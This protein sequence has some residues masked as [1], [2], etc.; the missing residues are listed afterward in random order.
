MAFKNRNH[1]DMSLFKNRLWALMDKNGYENPKELAAAL[2]EA[3]IKRAVQRDTSNKDP[4]DLT[5]SSDGSIEKTIQRHLN[6]NTPDRIKGEWMLVYSKFFGCSLDYLFG[7]E[8]CQEHGTQ[9]IHEY[10]GLTEKTI[11]TLHDWNQNPKTKNAI[12][13]L[14]DLVECGMFFATRVLFKIKD[15]IILRAVS[16]GK[17]TVNIDLFDIETPEDERLFNQ[18]IKEEKTIQNAKHLKELARFDLMNGLSDCVLTI[19]DRRKSVS[20]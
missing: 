15:Y 13:A 8:E 9:F 18:Q 10:I 11:E 3:R 20:K 1:S 2:R 17:P 16:E 14:N 7:I 5:K 19:Y 12:T 4:F 6:E